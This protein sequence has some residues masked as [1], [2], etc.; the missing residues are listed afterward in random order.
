MVRAEEH[1]RS[2]KVGVTRRRL[3][4]LFGGNHNAL[5]L[6]LEFL[7]LIVDNELATLRARSLV[8]KSRVPRI[9]IHLFDASSV[10]PTLEM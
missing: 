2:R 1:V 3:S 4:T 8:S 10:R 6:P 5:S 9:R 7:N